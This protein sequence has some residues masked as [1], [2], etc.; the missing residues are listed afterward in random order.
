MANM[1]APRAADDVLDS[2]EP[3]APTQYLVR[4]SGRRDQTGRISGPPRLP[5]DR[6]VLSCHFLTGID[7]LKDGDAASDPEVEIVAGFHLE[8]EGVRLSEVGHMDVIPDATP[9]GGRIVRP[10]YLGMLTFP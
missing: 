9:I 10:E 7:N 6:Y 2:I 3:R 1:P 4:L 8:S 5:Y